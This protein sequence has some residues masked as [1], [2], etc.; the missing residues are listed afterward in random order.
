MAARARSIKVSAPPEGFVYREELI[1]PDEEEHLI[2]E[3]KTLPLREFEFHGY[4]GKRRVISFGW[5]YD[6]DEARLDRA[7]EIPDFL[8]P[9]RAK[10]VQLADLAP[11]DLAHALVT[12][13][14]PGTPIGWHSDRPVFHE[15]IGISFLSAC[16]FRLRRKTAH[17][18]E[19]FTQTLAPR[20]AYLLTGA[21][22]R[23]WQHSITAVDELRYSVTFRSLRDDLAP[24][25]DFLYTHV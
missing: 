23:L 13:Y 11:G 16:Q 24:A 3:F 8:L 25:G 2:R 17:G 6:F 20:S 7:G 21:V 1:S 12:E 22:R 4:L 5:Q 18:W 9:L 10:A 15:V 19:R 14:T